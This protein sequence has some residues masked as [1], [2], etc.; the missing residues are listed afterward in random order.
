VLL[1]LDYWPLAR[2]RIAGPAGPDGAR[3]WGALAAGGGRGVGALVVEKIPFFVLTIGAAVA[4]YLAQDAAGATFGSIPLGLRLA[5]AVVSVARYLGMLVWPSGLAV[6]YPYPAAWPALAVGAALSLVVALTLLALWQRRRRPWIAVG[7]LWFL[8]M[9]V[10]VI[11]IVQVGIQA[12]ADRYTYLPILGVQ[13]A[14]LWTLR[15]FASTRSRRDAASAATGAALAASAL[16]T[17]VQVG[18]WRDAPTLFGDATVVTEDNFL[19]YSNLGMALASTQRYA[20]AEQ[21][22]R[23][24]LAIEPAHLPARTRHDNDYMLRYALAVTL[25]HQGR[26]DEAGEQ[27]ERVLEKIPDYLDAN[28]HY[29]VI[30]AMRNQPDVARSRFE[31]ALRHQPRNPIA[32]YNLAYLDFLEGSYDA[33][34]AGFRRSIE[35]APSSAGAHCGLAGALAAQ[36][37][38]DE[39]ARSREEARR[40]SGDAGACPG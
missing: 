17:F 7:W 3:A 27:L 40:L 11:G 32:L 26:Y 20:E 28:S 8:G 15:D 29:G 37:R 24:A 16:L 31:L 18:V 33:A 23:R 21:S 6:I 34:I 13:I 35:I 12:L 2:L 5:N 1:L 38:D 30:L 10:P 14:V 19:A 4:T 25:I 9:L 36:G 39:A 22:F